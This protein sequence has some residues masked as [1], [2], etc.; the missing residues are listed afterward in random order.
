[1]SKVNIDAAFAKFD[2]YW[3]PKIVAELN[4]QM[5]KLAR[6]SGEFIWHSHA[7][8][9]EL[10]LVLDGVLEIHF[11]DRDTVTL[12]QGE[13]AVIPRGVEHKPVARGQVRLML[14]EPSGTIN[15]G[16]IVDSRTRTN[17][18]RLE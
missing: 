14:F 12:C 8:E 15:T 16:E 10:F 2:G 1:M 18:D 6:L 11:R 3:D 4:G 5:V 13:L 7:K 9:D 17:L